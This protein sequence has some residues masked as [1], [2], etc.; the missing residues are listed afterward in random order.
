MSNVANL[1]VISTDAGFSNYLR[2][3]NAI[4][5]LTQEEEFMLAKAYLEKHDLNAAHRLVTS[6]LK[7]VAKMAMKY[8]NYGLPVSELVSE[9]NI[10]LMQAVKKYDPDTGYRLST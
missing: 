3:V 1:P 10:G 5:S 2:E 9:G 4:A 6:H 7:L 8:K